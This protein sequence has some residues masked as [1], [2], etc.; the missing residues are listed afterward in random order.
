MSLHQMICFVRSYASVAC[1]PDGWG[2]R[3]FGMNLE[4]IDHHIV[5]SY[6][7]IT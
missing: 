7:P 6:V 4:D 3:S 2:G 5:E 1:S